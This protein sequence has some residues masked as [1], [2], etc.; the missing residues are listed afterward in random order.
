M[1]IWATGFPLADE[2]LRIATHPAILRA[3]LGALGSPQVE[4]DVA[5]ACLHLLAKFRELSDEPMSEESV[6]GV[7]KAVLSL[8]LRSGGDTTA[9]PL[10][11]ILSCIK[12]FGG[13][14]YSKDLLASSSLQDFSQISQILRDATE[15]GSHK[16][17][18]EFN[19]SC[20]SPQLVA[21]SRRVVQEVIGVESTA[22]SIAFGKSELRDV[23][24]REKT[25]KTCGLAGC[26]VCSE[27][28]MCSRCGVVAYCTGR[29]A[30]TRVLCS[31]S[32][33]TIRSPYIF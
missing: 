31:A 7:A 13:L 30:R 32:P 16:C 2:C 12:L 20:L 9:L 26:N 29:V 33:H 21:V 5:T 22:S 8:L 3:C 11:F 19:E 24:Q 14:I 6:S 27:L 25:V 1:N 4:I 28:K 18:P 17:H 15:I 10:E 23:F